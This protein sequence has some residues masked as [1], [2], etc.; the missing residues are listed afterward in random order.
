L[1]C[2][3]GHIGG[4][5][6][7]CINGYFSLNDQC[8]QCPNNDY[9]LYLIIGVALLIIFFLIYKKSGGAV[10]P[11]YFSLSSMAVNH[12]QI[13][14]I[15]VSLKFEIP[16]LFLKVINWFQVICG[17]MFLDL[18]TSPECQVKLTFFQKW[19]AITSF[20]L[21]FI[22]ILQAIKVFHISSTN[23]TGMKI[24]AGA[25][26]FL[27]TLMYVIYIPA[28]TQTL[29]IFDCTQLVDGTYVLEWDPDIKCFE[30]IE[31]F[32][33]AG[34]SSIL[35]IFYVFFP[36]LLLNYYIHKKVRS[37]DE[38]NFVHWIKERYRTGY[39]SWEPFVIMPQKAILVFVDYFLFSLI[40]SF[41]I[42]FF[43]IG[44]ICYFHANWKPS[45]LF[46]RRLYCSLLVTS[47]NITTI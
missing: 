1:S 10:N 43:S 47:Y 22:I 34:I 32:V 29:K 16:E 37:D 24:A 21:A 40:I 19:L 35:G 8:Q 27:L 4:G 26:S 11:A 25:T 38:I 36:P 14:S 13:V 20:P 12:F 42:I 17:F 23:T 31:W 41:L 45:I 3:K 39:E 18:V 30:G 44:C 33:M 2:E 15:S 5:C 9:L 28:I 46:N 6:A 7:S